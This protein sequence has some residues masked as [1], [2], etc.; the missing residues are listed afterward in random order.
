MQIIKENTIIKD[1]KKNKK[2]KKINKSQTFCK[3]KI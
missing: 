3:M 1:K 2:V